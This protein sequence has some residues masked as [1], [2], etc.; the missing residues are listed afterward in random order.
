MTVYLLRL[1]DLM[2]PRRGTLTGL[3]QVF[4]CCLSCGGE[5][6]SAW[7]VGQ[8]TGPPWLAPVILPSH[9]SARDINNNSTSGFTL[10]SHVNPFHCSNDC[11]RSGW[12]GLIPT[13]PPLSSQFSALLLS[14]FISASHLI[15]Q[16]FLVQLNRKRGSNSVDVHKEAELNSP[17]FV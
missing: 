13:A 14:V 8:H 11:Y 7:V 15:S 4:C 10:L 5:L 1:F 17:L 16:Y 2:T 3:T 12:P 9:S 6:G